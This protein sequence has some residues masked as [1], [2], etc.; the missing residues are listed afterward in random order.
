MHTQKGA[1]YTFR[2][3]EAEPFLESTCR[4]YP[5]GQGPTLHITTTALSA[6]EIYKCASVLPRQFLFPLLD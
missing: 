1:F 6:T 3:A 4:A 2:S 5:P